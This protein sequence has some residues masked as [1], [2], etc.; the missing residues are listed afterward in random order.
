MTVNTGWGHAQHA[1]DGNIRDG[2]GRERRRM[3]ETR[4]PFAGIW[5]LVTL[6]GLIGIG[7]GLFALFAP[8]ATLISLLVILAVYLMV[9]GVFG[10]VSAALAGRAGERW[11]L[12]VVEAVANLVAG[13]AVLAWP[14]LTLLV[15]VLLLAGWAILTGALMIGTAINLKRDGRVWLG[16]SGVV[17]VVFGIVLAVA[18]IIGAVVVT[19]WLGIYALVFGTVLVV[20]GLHLR[21]IAM[22]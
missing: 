10:L 18:P 1:H 11:D 9:D 8:V 13:A 16:L 19:W 20:F 3:G 6:R 2:E 14:A 12:L 22:E 7:F 4:R 5:W 17:S 21:S 15:L